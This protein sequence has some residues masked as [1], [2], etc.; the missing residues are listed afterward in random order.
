MV[1]VQPAQMRAMLPAGTVERVAPRAAGG[2]LVA[3]GLFV[4]AHGLRLLNLRQQF[5]SP[6]DGRPTLPF[7][8]VIGGT[9]ALL[10]GIPVT[11]FGVRL[12]VRP[13]RLDEQVGRGLL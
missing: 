11:I 1:G 9:A 5:V 8:R 10:F 7:L 3:L 4:H 12:I 2:V 13:A 6:H